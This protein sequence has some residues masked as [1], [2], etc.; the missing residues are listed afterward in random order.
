M[1]IKVTN[2]SVM[3]ICIE[4]NGNAHEL[5]KGQYV[6][7]YT[8]DSYAKINAISRGES[9][10]SINLLDI[11]TGLFLGSSTYT[12][13]NCNYTFT[14]EG[15]NDCEVILENNFVAKSIGSECNFESVCANTIGCTLADECYYAEDLKKFKK[16][17]T[18]LQLF[19]FSGLPIYILLA[20]LCLI[21]KDWFYMVVSVIIFAICTVPSIIR[22]FKFKR[23]LKNE[24]ISNSLTE[25][26]KLLREYNFDGLKAIYDKSKILKKMFRRND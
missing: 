24:T 21:L 2:N 11:F 8:E 16:K 3:N 22:I 6:F 17:N 5:T 13:I 25:N 19:V 23:K 1:K 7:L 18:R 14:V 15:E 4:F 10:V 9:S 26:A 20:L 12:I